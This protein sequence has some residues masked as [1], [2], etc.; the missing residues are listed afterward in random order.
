[1]SDK[2]FPR[3]CKHGTVRCLIPP[4]K[5]RSRCFKSCVELS[6]HRRVCRFGRISREIR[7]HATSSRI[8]VRS[9]FLSKARDR[10]RREYFWNAV[11]SVTS[12]NATNSY[13][14]DKRSSMR[15]DSL[16]GTHV[17]T[18]SVQLHWLESFE[19]VDQ[20]IHILPNNV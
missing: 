9:V 11:Q 4:C 1:M 10:T 3:S 19:Q 2:S 16:A 12:R 20:T 8:F 18:H 17:A 7:V 6:I 14:R 15:G 13:E 5:N